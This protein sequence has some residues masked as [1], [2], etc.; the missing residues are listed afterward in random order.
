MLENKYLANQQKSK[1]IWCYEKHITTLCLSSLLCTSQTALSRELSRFIIILTKKWSCKYML[2]PWRHW[3]VFV[4]FTWIGGCQ[5]CHCTDVTKLRKVCPRIHFKVC[6][7]HAFVKMSRVS[8]C[9]IAYMLF[10]WQSRYVSKQDCCLL[11][12]LINLGTLII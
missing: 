5:C 10:A 1:D 2:I 12:Y 4:E 9:L 8:F 3:R 6:W 11:S 7:H